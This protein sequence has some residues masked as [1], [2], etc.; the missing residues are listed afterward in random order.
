[1]ELLDLVVIVAYVAMIVGVGC[2]AGWRGLSPE[3][4]GDAPRKNSGAAG[5]YFL[6]G[7]TLRWPMIGLAMFSTN[8]STVHLVGL[9]EAGYLS[10]LLMGNFELMAGVTLAILALFFAPFYIRSR[11]VTLPDFLEQRYSRRSRDI[12]AVISV[13]SAIFVHIG[14]SLYTGAVV[15]NGIFN[16]NLPK[17]ASVLVIAA[18]T[19][20]YTILGGLAAVVV[21]ESI[22][23]I[24]LLA[25][26][27]LITA[28]AWFRA[29]GWEG[30]VA[31]IP[32]SHLTMLRASDAPGGLPW[33]S[34][35]LGYPVIGI[36][37]WCTD[38]TIVQR[39]L[40]ARDENH[41][42]AGALF[43]G[44]LKIF[45]LFIFV[46]PG[47]ICLALV[48]QGKLSADRVHN[49]ADVYAY[50]IRELLPVGVKGLVAAALIAAVM[51][52][53]SGAL[54][55]IGTLVSYDLLKRF[56]PDA[57][58][59]QLVSVGRWA[60]F[61]SLVL[62]I[63]WSLSLNPDGIFQAI[64]AMIT[65][66]APPMT[67]VFLF[68]IFWRRASSDAAVATLTVGT[69]CGAA[70]L[71]LQQF[72][73][74]W[75]T[76]AVTRLRLDFLLIGVALFVICSIVMVVVSLLRP[77]QHTAKSAALVW[78]SP[79]EPLQAPG[80]PGFG[81]YKFLTSLLLGSLATIY[82]LFS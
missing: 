47:L 50:L 25:S 49:T 3:Q 27:V 1:M 55:S 24:V 60:S 67:C 20:V 31:N 82:Y 45:P 48:Q 63:L 57:S 51:A 2:W 36:W 21:T 30:I 7:G 11:V 78:N 53:V 73:V 58:D 81:N 12:V 18:L 75:W 28:F 42:R 38:Q 64:N 68:G 40:G 61:V 72:K 76:S 37:Y 71:L 77:H 4:V 32:A 46:M 39:V 59:R 66:I 41:A 16:L 23:T 17:S 34:I 80:W 13:L 44:F 70:V 9:A 19:G 15:L 43:A 26:A 62:A 52:S 74:A 14:F 79:W 65:Y 22:Q 33:Y 35:V 10:G 69:A 8:I 54:N 29:G 56:R 5:S 6:A